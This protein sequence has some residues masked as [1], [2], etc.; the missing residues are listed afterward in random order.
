MSGCFSCKFAIEARND[1][2]RGSQVKCQKAK[3]LFN[4]K[5]WVDAKDEA[6]C[7]THEPFKGSPIDEQLKIEAPKPVKV[8]CTSCQGRGMVIIMIGDEQQSMKCR[9]CEGHGTVESAP[10]ESPVD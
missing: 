4:Y 9:I 5:G 10:E 8:K 2:R 1:I 3:E 6:T 7:G